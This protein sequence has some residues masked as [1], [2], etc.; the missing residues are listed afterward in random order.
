MGLRVVV[1]RA[2]A[3]VPLYARAPRVPGFGRK[4]PL[5]H[6][7]TIGWQSHQAEGLGA[8]GQQAPRHATRDDAST[9]TAGATAARQQSPD[10]RAA[11]VDLQLLGVASAPPGHEC[12]HGNSPDELELTDQSFSLGPIVQPTFRFDSERV[13]KHAVSF[14]GVR[15]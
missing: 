2:I 15:T 3:R 13:S 4:Q 12:V 6:H 10:W 8:R 5:G 7:S 9:S 1:G 11:R 14:N